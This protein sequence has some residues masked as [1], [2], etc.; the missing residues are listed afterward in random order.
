M[1]VAV[2]I[3]AGLFA[4][5]VHVCGC[6]G[7]IG[8]CRGRGGIARP[9]NR[10]PEILKDKSVGILNKGEAAKSLLVAGIGKAVDFRHLQHIQCFKLV[11]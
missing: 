8:H 10:F 1:F 2:V 6:G 9:R 7:G 11:Q 5:A 4:Q 3:E